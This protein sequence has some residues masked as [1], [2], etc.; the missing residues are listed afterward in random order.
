VSD[1]KA[2][3]TS[4]HTVLLWDQ[5][6]PRKVSVPGTG[7]MFSDVTSTGVTVGSSWAPQPVPWVSTGTAVTKLPGIETGE[8][9]AVNEQGRIAGTDES[10]GQRQPV[11]WASPDS[12]P[13]RLPLPEGYISGEALD[14]DE[15]GTVAGTLAGR[16][17][18]GLRVASFV[19]RA[20]GTV[21]QV[22]VAV[23][24]AEARVV[25]VAA[26]RNGWVTGTAQLNTGVD[27]A[28]ASSPRATQGRS[29]GTDMAISYRWNLYT[30]ELR[31]Y[32]EGYLSVTGVTVHGWLYGTDAKGRA[33]LATDPDDPAAGALTMPA[34]ADLRDG[35]DGIATA[36]SDDGRSAG[37]QL[38]D[39]QG[40]VRPV[41]WSCM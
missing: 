15:D 38:L 30:G 3:K 31:T 39:R 25:S 22:P 20:D 21:Q 34:P 1:P 7:Q 14:I 6:I 41:A 19:W 18:G 9:K 13:Q 36:V 23:A 5:G 17:D 2:D 4:A 8:A 28:K 26:I 16:L 29:T 33:A 11:V 35:T 37:G 40:L 24:G 32:R 10:G 27:A 12:P